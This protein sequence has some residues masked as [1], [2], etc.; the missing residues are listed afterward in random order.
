MKT[1]ETP[2]GFGVQW[3]LARKTDPNLIG[4]LFNFQ[5][6]VDR[7]FEIGSA[8]FRSCCE[9]LIDKGRG[10]MAKS[11][12]ADCHL[13]KQGFTPGSCG[14]KVD[15]KQNLACQATLKRIDGRP[16][17][18]ITSVH[19]SRPENY[20]SIYQ[21]GCNFSC[22][23]CHSWYFSKVKDGV[24]YTPADILHKAREY[25]KN[26]TLWEPREKATAWHAHDTC[27]CCGACV[28]HRT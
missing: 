6:Q 10:G 3:I 17:R 23:K 2:R 25:E 16:H 19:L 26:V 11:E 20:L 18:L 5:N 15:G 7:M 27:R 28:L 9:E 14:V 12:K 13:K 8:A 1:Q 22:R 21:S 24:W 4:I